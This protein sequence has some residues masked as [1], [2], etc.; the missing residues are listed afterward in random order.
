MAIAPKSQ[1]PLKTELDIFNEYS[2]KAAAEDEKLTEDLANYDANIEQATEPVDTK[3]EEYNKSKPLKELMFGIEEAGA[4]IN[5]AISGLGTGFAD[6]RNAI[7]MSDAALQDVQ[8]RRAKF[9]DE[10]TKLKA[11]REAAAKKY[12]AG[13]GRIT[14]DYKLQQGLRNQ[15]Y[16]RQMKGVEVAEAYGQIPEPMQL[17]LKYWSER[18]G[19]K[20]PTEGITNKRAPEYLNFLKDIAEQKRVKEGDAPATKAEIELA[21]ANIQ[22]YGGTKVPM[23]MLGKVTQKQLDKHQQSA[24]IAGGESRRKIEQYGVKPIIESDE[25]GNTVINLGKMLTEEYLSGK[26]QEA[27]NKVRLEDRKQYINDMK[28]IEPIKSMIRSTDNLKL[29]NGETNWVAFAQIT[30]AL[31]RVIGGEKGVLTEQDVARYSGNVS[32]A[33]SITRGIDKV[34]KGQTK[35]DDDIKALQYYLPMILSSRLQEAEERRSRVGG[36]VNQ[37][38][39]TSDLPDD[40]QQ[41]ITNAILGSKQIKTI[42]IKSNIPEDFVQAF[43]KAFSD[44]NG[45]LPTQQ[46]IDNSWSKQNNKK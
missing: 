12:E 43:S 3:I 11:D 24:V 33:A 27:L 26:Q 39:K 15:A 35:S 31:P 34:M 1:S 44:K 19:Y 9:S 13:R 16:D 22:Q 8:G 17:Q 2:T 38:L 40:V 7:G 21:N 37:I 28:D 36:T 20:L 45:R 18:A 32:A 30:G 29:P 23:S 10:L 4:N 14:E 42:Q 6:T 46:E 41:N 5:K 25:K